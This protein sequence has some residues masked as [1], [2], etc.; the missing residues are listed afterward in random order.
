MYLD[1][2]TDEKASSL[3]Y[4]QL[5]VTNSVR[6]FHLA[7]HNV[8]AK[9]VTVATSSEKSLYRKLLDIEFM[10]LLMLY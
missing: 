4:H 8:V 2:G 1:N 6:C 7:T 10:R 5:S 3:K 9:L